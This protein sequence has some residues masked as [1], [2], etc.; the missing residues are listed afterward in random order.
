MK[1]FVWVALLVLSL[2]LVSACGGAKQPAGQSGGEE[3][4][5]IGLAISTLNNPFFVDLRDGAQAAADAAGFKLVVLDAQDDPSAQVSQIEDLI[6][7][8]VD[9]L[10]I[11]PT[12]SDAI[13]TAVEAA[14]AANIP[15]ITVDRGA[16]GGEV[17]AH[18]LARHRR[19]GR[20]VEHII[21]DL[22]STAEF[23]PERRHRLFHLGRRP[24]ED[25]S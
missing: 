17:V 3:K 7:Q 23:P 11:N 18:V 4:T 14:N 25:G 19:I 9:A 12:D 1:R 10:L 22:K 24:G 20:I 6:T 21:D 15:V 16:S 13:V 5:T 2:G 8:K